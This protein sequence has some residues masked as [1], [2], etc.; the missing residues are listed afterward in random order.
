MENYL[1]STKRALQTT[2][3]LEMWLKYNGVLFWGVG[4]R[5]Q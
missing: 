1:S 5:P 2:L 3:I 4:K